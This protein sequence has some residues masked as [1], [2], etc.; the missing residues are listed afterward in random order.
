M[1][2]RQ[3]ARRVHER[4]TVLGLNSEDYGASALR[5]TKASI[6]YKQ[7]GNPRSAQGLAPLEAARLRA[8]SCRADASPGNQTFFVARQA[9]AGQFALARAG[10]ACLAEPSTGTYW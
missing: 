4:N 7:T 3:Y 10:R 2:T 8:A 5:R 6:L 9:H 1:S